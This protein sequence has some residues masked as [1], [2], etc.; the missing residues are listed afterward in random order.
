M[1]IFNLLFFLKK[2]HKSQGYRWQVAL[3]RDSLIMKYKSFSVPTVVI[4]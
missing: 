3:D 4:M 1:K 2:D